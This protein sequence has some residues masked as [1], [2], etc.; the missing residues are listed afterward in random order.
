[1]NSFMDGFNIF[2]KLLP[3]A[4]LV[5][6]LINAIKRSIDG[7]QSNK[8]HSKMSVIVVIILAILCGTCY[9]FLS[10]SDGKAIHIKILSI[11]LNCSY[12][13]CLAINFYEIIMK[14]IFDFVGNLF[15]KIS[16]NTPD[17]SKIIEKKINDEVNKT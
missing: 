6:L 2:L 15:K 4:I 12:I 16:N 13:W 14:G 9:Y 7:W 1:M 11:I 5:V 8:P 17:V 10:P 3:I